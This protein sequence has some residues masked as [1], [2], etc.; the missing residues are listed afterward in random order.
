MASTNPR[1]SKKQLA[2]SAPALAV[3]CNGGAPVR[4][5][6]HPIIDSATGLAWIAQC[7]LEVH[8]AA[9]VCRR[10]RI[11]ELNPGPATRLVSDLDP[12]KGG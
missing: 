12:S 7:A 11:S 1:S 6:F 2:L 5:R 9:G 4:R 3:T 10:A 8:R